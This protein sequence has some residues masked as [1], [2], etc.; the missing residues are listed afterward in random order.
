MGYQGTGTEY[1]TS[2]QLLG[3]SLIMDND[4]HIIGVRY[5]DRQRDRTYSFFM[6]SRFRI[7]R[8]FR[9]NPRLRLDYR[10]AKLND[11]RRLII[12]PLLKMD[13]RVGKW[14]YLEL[15]GGWEWRDE[16]YSGI[17]QTSTGN[18]IYA[19]YRAIF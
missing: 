16:T 1:Y 13:Y 7:G 9:I 14:L 19:G 4:S 5:N 10:S 8:N 3:S 11:N 17:K 2:L 12:R 15:E 18:Y 6:N